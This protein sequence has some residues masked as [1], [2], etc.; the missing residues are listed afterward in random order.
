MFGD[1]DRELETTL[2]T[3]NAHLRR[4]LDENSS[5]LRRIATLQEELELKR[6]DIASKDREIRETSDELKNTQDKM[7]A[8]EVDLGLERVKRMKELEETVQELEESKVQRGELEEQLNT[9][10][11]SMTL[12]QRTQER[13]H[14]EIVL[15]KDETIQDQ[16][17]EI[18]SLKR[19]LKRQVK[20]LTKPLRSDTKGK[21]PK[22]S[23]LIIESSSEEE[24]SREA[25]CQLDLDRSSGDSDREV[26]SDH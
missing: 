9:L 3:K 1:R 5:Y 13:S 10:R 15:H 24:S 21:R 19:Q 22:Q 23:P 11:M 26:N 25:I 12:D 16:N 2:Q 7:D 20:N 17:R 4:V 6:Q 14:R 18:E 8:L